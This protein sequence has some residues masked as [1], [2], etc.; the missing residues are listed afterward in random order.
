LSV[1]KPPVVVVTK[2]SRAPSVAPGRIVKVAV[3]VVAVKVVG[4]AGLPAAKPFTSMNCSVLGPIWS[5]VLL[6]QFVNVPVIVIGTLEFGIPMLGLIWMMLGVPGCTV[7]EFD[8][9]NC[10]PPVVT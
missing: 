1:C 3:I 7:K 8:R 2:T 9:Y 5:L 10:C 6:S 4:V